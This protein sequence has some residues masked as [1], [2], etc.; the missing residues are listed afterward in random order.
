MVGLR[1][2]ARA[3]TGLGVEQVAL[4]AV[5]GDRERS[6]KLWGA[7]VRPGPRRRPRGLRGD[8]RGASLSTGQVRPASGTAAVGEFFRERKG[9]GALGGTCHRDGPREA[10]RGG[11][12]SAGGGES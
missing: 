4:A 10:A 5:G 6:A 1:L 2:A 9:P 3:R 8:W 7:S 11:H 12:R